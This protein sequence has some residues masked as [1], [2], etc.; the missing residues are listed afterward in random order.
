MIAAF[1]ELNTYL[2]I[3]IT[4]ALIIIMY[5]SCCFTLEANSNNI[6]EHFI[7]LRTSNL[8]VLRCR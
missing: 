1:I 7:V 5:V 6:L 8:P 3:N 4:S 2:Y